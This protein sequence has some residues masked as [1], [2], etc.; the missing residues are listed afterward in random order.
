MEIT[1]T[2][3]H[4]TVP[5]KFK[6]KIQR[7]IEKLS[8]YNEAITEA[9]VILSTQKTTNII[10]VIL[11]GKDLKI[12]AKEEAE[13]M[14]DALNLVVETL[15]NT[16]K[17]ERERSKKERK[18][19][20]A[21]EDLTMEKIVA[22]LD[23]PKKK[24]NILYAGDNE[25]IVKHNELLK[26]ISPLEAILILKENALKFYAFNNI[27]TNRVCVIYKRNDKR[28]GMIEM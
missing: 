10:E 9:K 7:K 19:T 27:D 21:A 1:I 24:Q 3:R 26:P 5:E 12:T 15:E 25:I 17:K 13:Q 18:K 23:K 11:T 22:D 8:K 20:K 4:L 14:R 16:L 28:Y 6:E 2:G